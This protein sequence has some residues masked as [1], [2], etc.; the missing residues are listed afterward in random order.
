M[1]DPVEWLSNRL[2]GV[3]A[4]AT[5]AEI[6]AGSPWTVE[7]N[8][9]T[10]QRDLVVASSPLPG[11]TSPVYELWSAEGSDDVYGSPAVAV[12][13]AGMDP[14]TV[15]RLVAATRAVL[16]EHPPITAISDFPQPTPSVQRC[17]RCCDIDGDGHDWEP[18]PWP[19]PTLRAVAAGWGWVDE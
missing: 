5:A 13:V 8:I 17:S 9:P 14:E 16:D 18:L 11:F 6:D 3:E 15:L 4:L 7:E 2:D 19:C 1:S 12:H 10:D